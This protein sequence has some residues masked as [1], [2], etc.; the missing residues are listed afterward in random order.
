MKQRKFQNITSTYSTEVIFTGPF[1]NILI[2]L[3]YIN[4]EISALG[5]CM[6][7]FSTLNKTVSLGVMN[8]E[9]DDQRY[10]TMVSESRVHN[11]NG[12]AMLPDSTVH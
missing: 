8:T 3:Y 7:V 5:M 12:S 9:S 1:G 4:S 2:F 11:I 6:F 10:S